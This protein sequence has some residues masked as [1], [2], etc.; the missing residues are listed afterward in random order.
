M[1]SKVLIA[2]RGLIQTNCVRAV[3]ELGAKAIAIFEE[4][5]RNSAG[6]RN[7]DE[8]HKLTS[9][10]STRAY[11]DIDQIV[12]LAV[13]LKVDAVLS[14]YGFLAQNAEFSKKLRRHGI[15]P[16]APKLE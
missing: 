8:V 2:N 13:S 10:S 1:F 12:K 6:V 15:V 7:A 3:Q 4:E 16:I 9:T 14:G 5:D 11:A